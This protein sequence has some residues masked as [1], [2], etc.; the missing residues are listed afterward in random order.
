MPYIRKEVR[1][2]AATNPYNPGELNYCLTRQIDLY[3]GD[4]PNYRLINEVIGVLECAKMELYRR[5]AAPYEDKKIIENGDVYGSKA[6][7][8]GS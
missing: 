6:R 7:G 2:E 5:I 3:L 4:R 8:F 1:E